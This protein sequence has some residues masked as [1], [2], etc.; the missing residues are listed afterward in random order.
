M[1]HSSSSSPTSKARKVAPQSSEQDS[2]VVAR[3]E[4]DLV[5]VVFI[6]GFKG[7][8]ETFG[9]FPQRLQHLLSETLE[10]TTVEVV[11]FPA[12][13]VRLYSRRLHLRPYL[14]VCPNC[15]RKAN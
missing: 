4:S 8:D 5:L 12:Y 9:D 6:H 10:R 11:V 14:T 3:Q 15:R 1:A 7:T 2:L 13:E